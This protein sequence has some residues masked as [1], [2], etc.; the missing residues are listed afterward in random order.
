MR[1]EWLVR[2]EKDIRGLDR[3]SMYN[4]EMA[5][6]RSVLNFRFLGRR[7]QVSILAPTHSPCLFSSKKSVRL[8]ITSPEVGAYSSVFQRQGR[9]SC[10]RN[11]HIKPRI[12]RVVLRRGSLLR[13]E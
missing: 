3:N 9:G 11:E 10:N 5:D 13:T 1:V 12:F 7:S 8:V 2:G 6:R 4:L